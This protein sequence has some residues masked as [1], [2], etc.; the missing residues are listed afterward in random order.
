MRTE[1]DERHGGLHVCLEINTSGGFFELSNYIITSV[2]H[3]VVRSDNKFQ[4]LGILHQ[5]V[6]KRYRVKPMKLESHFLS[7]SY[8]KLYT[9]VVF[10]AIIL[11][12]SDRIGRCMKIATIHRDSDADSCILERFIVI[13]HSFP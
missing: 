9:L 13:H 3:I 8:M 4:L 1:G 5:P 6:A 7:L 11:Q 12:F 10:F 2:N